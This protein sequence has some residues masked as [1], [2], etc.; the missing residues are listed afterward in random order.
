MIDKSKIDNLLI[1]LEGQASQNRLKLLWNTYI[2][3]QS[4]LNTSPSARYI[5]E[6]QVAENALEDFFTEFEPKPA[7]ETGEAPPFPAPGIPGQ[8][9]F[10]LPGKQERFCQEYLKDLNATQSYIRAGYKNKINS[11]RVMAHRLLQKPNIQKRIAFLQAERAREVKVSQ[12]DV[13]RLLVEAVSK[14][15]DKASTTMKWSDKIRAI[16]LLGKHVGMFQEGGRA[17][18][19]QELWAEL[20]K[21]EEEADATIGRPPKTAQDQ[22]KASPGGEYG[23]EGESPHVAQEEKPRVLN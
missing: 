22:S 19:P 12:E 4:N 5:K 14:D 11:A 6:L 21:F 17:M 18:D 7:E 9:D 10:R 15:P 3:I 1:T 20:R 16:E 8:D 2:A 23:G 13:L